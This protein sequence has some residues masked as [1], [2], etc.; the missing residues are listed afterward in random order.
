MSVRIDPLREHVKL[1]YSGVKPCDEGAPGAIGMSHGVQLDIVGVAV[2]LDSIEGP[3][4]DPCTVH[5][6]GIDVR[7]VLSIVRPDNDCT[8]QAVRGSPPQYQPVNL[9]LPAPQGAII[10]LQLDLSQGEHRVIGRLGMADADIF[11]DQSVDEVQA[12]PGEGQVNA[13]RL[14]GLHQAP[15]QKIRQADATRP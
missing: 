15:F 12:H 1:K 9:P 8:A 3:L 5:P 7:R 10:Q 6:L 11:D 2:N 4:G 13:A 14:Q